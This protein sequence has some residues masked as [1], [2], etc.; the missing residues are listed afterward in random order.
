[1][2]VLQGVKPSGKG[3]VAKCPAHDDRQQSLSVSEGDD[4][5]ILVTCFAGCETQHIVEAVGWKMKDLFP[6]NT[7]NFGSLSPV[8]SSSSSTKVTGPAI[9][10][11]DLAA[12]KAIPF[13]FLSFYCEQLPFGVKVIYKNMDGKPASRQRLRL[14]LSAKE[15]S[16]WT[17]GPGN[18]IPYGVWR[19]GRLSQQTDTLLFVEGESDS[20]TAWYH[21]IGALG[22]PGADMTKKIAKAHI[23]PFSKL[24]IWK[25]PDQG[26][27]TFVH[28]IT[29]RL[30]G[31]QYDGQV[32]IVQGPPD[33]NG[34]PVKDLNQLH[35][36]ALAAGVPFKDLWAQV[37]DASQPVDMQA[38]AEAAQKSI[39]RHGSYESG[40]GF[41]KPFSGNSLT[42]MGNADRIVSLFGQDILFCYAWNKWLVWNG[43]YWEKDESGEI[44]RKAE[45]TVR[46]IYAEAAKEEDRDLRHEL[47]KHAKSSESAS[48]IRAMLDR[49]KNRVPAS[50]KQFDSN[51]WLFNCQNGTINLKTG[52]LLPHVRS[53][54]ITKISPASYD[55]KAEAP[56]WREFLEQVTDND[57]ELISFLQRAAGYALT[58][59]TSEHC[60]FF[61]HGDGRNGKSVFIETVKYVIGDY[62]TTARPDVLM[63][64]KY[65]ESVPNE[66]AA[67]AGV[68]YVSTTETESGKRF[69]ESMLKQYTGDDIISARFLYGEFF[70]FKPQFK[71]F[72]AS[73]HKPIIR[74]QDTAIWERIYLIPFTVYIPPEKRDKKLGEKLQAE[75]DGILRWAVEGCLAWQREGLNPPDVV[76]GATESYR[77]EMDP[78]RDFFAERCVFVP[79]ATVFVSDLW[80]AYLDWCKENSEKYPLTKRLFRTHLLQKKLEEKRTSKRYWQGIGLRSEIHGIQENFEGE[81]WSGEQ[82]E[83]AASKEEISN[84]NDLGIVHK[85]ETGFREDELY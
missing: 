25:E 9:T 59:D 84:T 47:I 43:K 42:D 34:V 5:R 44:D 21:D 39:S 20:W 58:G 1:M 73:N 8:S 40:S 35:K 51:I 36:N 37:L 38:A 60:L 57:Q 33:E 49:A 18:P 52:D 74:G 69:A 11:A 72:L 62:G 17:K 2:A 55:P 29:Y 15:G 46:S 13:D 54:M 45:A 7:N 85:E 27:E 6:K 83:I 70:T 67:L 12:D 22:L 79:E 65:G 41:V 24:L 16:K 10:I 30:V 76:R 66:I 78:L 32:F 4:G 53:N 68:R 80:N 28:G 64:K 71:I 50:P 26:G 3:Y 61:L 23:E 19:I 31:L 77:D 75:V 56:R 82:R 81:N 63:S 14:A 48:K